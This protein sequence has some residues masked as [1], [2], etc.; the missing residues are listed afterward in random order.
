MLCSGEESYYFV[1]AARE[2]NKTAYKNFKEANAGKLLKDT[3]KVLGGLGDFTGLKLGNRTIITTET[4]DKIA[5]NK[6]TKML[7][8]VGLSAYSPAGA[9]LNGSITNKIGKAI[10]DTEI[11]SK[12]SDSLQK[13]FGGKN[14]QFK[15]TA[16]KVF[17]EEGSEGAETILKN[18]NMVD[19]NSMYKRFKELQDKHTFSN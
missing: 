19:S 13:A 6:V 15:A 17:K 1:K 2:A 9:L 11:G 7:T 3:E 18:I 4:L 14:S 16:K 10:E 5:S 12:A 8:E